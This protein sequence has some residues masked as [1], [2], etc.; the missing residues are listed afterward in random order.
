MGRSSGL[1]VKARDQLIELISDEIRSPGSHGEVLKELEEHFPEDS[2]L[3]RFIA[4]KDDQHRHAFYLKAQHAWY[5]RLGWK[6]MRPLFVVS[7]LAAIGFSLQRVV[8]PT[9]GVASFLG[10]AAAMYIVLQI[11]A[12]RWAYKELGKMDEVNARYREKLEGLLEDLR[13]QGT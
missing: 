12:H 2:A 1:K 7:V 4:A 13:G 6:I 10:G 5:R 9:L 3:L 11:F 8:D